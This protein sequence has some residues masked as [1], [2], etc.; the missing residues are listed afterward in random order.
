MEK[1]RYLFIILIGLFV[2]TSS[3][4]VMAQSNVPLNTL[5]ERVEFHFFTPELIEQTYLQVTEPKFLDSAK[6]ITL[7]QLD[8]FAQ[9]SDQLS[10][11]V[12]QH[13]ARG[14]LIVKEKRKS[15][16]FERHKNTKKIVEEF[17]FNKNEGVAVEINK[18]NGRFIRWDDQAYPGGVLR[19]VQNETFIELKSTVLNK[20]QLIEIAENMK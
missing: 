6:P 3:A 19:W 15:D 18:H 20:E 2:F 9:E 17:K 4:G 10:L 14:H 13:R 16:Q 12:T 5:R 1:G 8:Y 11:T 7:V